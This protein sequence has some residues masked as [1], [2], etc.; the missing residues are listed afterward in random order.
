MKFYISLIR[1]YIFV[2]AWQ[3]KYIAITKYSKQCQKQK[4]GVPRKTILCWTKEFDVAEKVICFEQKQ[5]H[6][7]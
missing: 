6:V 7:A 5:V 3:Q 2:A 1:D 4:F